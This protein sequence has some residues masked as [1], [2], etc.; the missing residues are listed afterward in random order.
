M[1]RRLLAFA[2]HLKTPRLGDGA[3]IYNFPTKLATH[4]SSA[5]NNTTAIT[6][7]N[8]NKQYCTKTSINSI[9][10]VG[11]EEIKQLT[12]YPNKLLIDVR[13]P[14]E[15]QETGR[16]PTSI[17]IP[18]DQVATALADTVDAGAFKTKYGRDFPSKATEVI[19]HCRSGK[20]SQKAAETAKK[21]GYENAKNY[22]GS[23][24]EWA[25]KEGLSK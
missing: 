24:N 25:E 19:F 6:R 8:F 10:I 13:E 15:L 23:W 2:K 4:T 14:E 3:V 12:K 11:Y 5:Y 20:R 17:N 9:P 16:I 22:L 7:I 18:L 21:L 1:S